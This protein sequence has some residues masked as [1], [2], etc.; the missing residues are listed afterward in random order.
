MLMTYNYK[1]R[2]MDEETKRSFFKRMK[3]V[4]E[5]MRALNFYSYVGFWRKLIR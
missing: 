1:L 5:D 2:I 3:I 4:A